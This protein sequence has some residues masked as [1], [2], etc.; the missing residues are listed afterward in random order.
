MEFERRRRGT[1]SCIAGFEAATGRV[2]DPCLNRTR[3]PVDFVDAIART[4]ATD[5]NGKRIF[6]A[7]GLTTRVSEEKVRLVASRRGS[8]LNQAEVFFPF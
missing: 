6:V 4:V 5:P 3:K 8:W 2:F 7:D 1:I